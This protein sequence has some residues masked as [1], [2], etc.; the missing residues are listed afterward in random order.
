MNIQNPIEEIKSRLDIVQVIGSY[1]KLQKAGI[2][3][4]AVCPFHSEKKPSLFVSPTRQIW[5]CFG[6]GLGGDIFAFVKE[7][8]RV[9]FGDALRILARKAG[10]ELKKPTSEM[11]KWQTE[12]TRLYEICELANK[13]FEKQLQ[14]GNAGKKAKQYLLD[15][16]LKEETI[17]KWR[18]GYA[19]DTWQGLSDFLAEAG[20]K[21]EE[22]EKAGLEIKNEKGNFYDR[23]R[24]RIIFPVFDLNSQIAGF[25]GRIFQE[26]KG[27]DQAKYINTPQTLLYD[28]GNILYGLDKAKVEIRKKDCCI[29]VEGYMDAI[30]CS[31]AGFE[32]VAAVS[33]TA[34]T[35]NQLKTLKR[36]SENLYTAFDMDIAGG[37]ATQRGIDLAQA[38]G[39]KIKVIV[40]PQGKDP[41]DIILEGSDKWQDLV[42]RAKSITEFYF[43]SAFSSAE[44]DLQNVENKVKITKILLPVIK[45]IFN[46]IEQSHWLGEL[47]NRLKIK[48]EDLRTELERA[49][50]E[51]E[52]HLPSSEKES[53]IDAE[54]NRK[55]KDRKDMLEERLAF[56]LLKHPHDLDLIREDYFCYFSDEFKKILEYLKQNPGLKIDFKE[57]KGFPSSKN[58]S[59]EFI[60]SLNYLCLAAEVDYNPLKEDAEEDGLPEPEEEIEICLE[61]IKGFE[62]RKELNKTSDEIKEAEKE[63]DPEKISSL[64]QKFNKL[65]KKLIN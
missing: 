60:E 61:E 49:K 18:I 19:P 45:K 30:L 40:M 27:T 26:Q 46:K 42:D 24:G 36:Y 12:K 37:S 9:E 5:K 55:P 15:R 20:Y 48:E 25:G 39:F 22:I 63:N 51:K 65:S 41:A 54:E 2:N 47:S 31:Q 52:T 16:G 62:I 64:V 6:C 50:F 53:E 13:F 10:I 33:G 28:K 4:K 34:L 3:Y 35:Q 29:L 17:E 58:F 1:I 7:I 38:Q 23:F 21:K 44:G 32:N 43:Q 14:E 11:A 59:P 56:L 8:E 57:K